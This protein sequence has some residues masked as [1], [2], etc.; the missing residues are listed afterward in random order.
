MKGGIF[1]FPEKSD[2]GIT[3]NY[4]YIT[5]SAIASKV[6]NALL[7]NC[8]KSDIEKILRKIRTAF[9]E[10]AQRSHRF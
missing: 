3:K 4:R 7:L 9:K 6:H 8:I 1:P 5:L 2:I 10:S